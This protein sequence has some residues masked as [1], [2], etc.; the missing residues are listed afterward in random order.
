[1]SHT[2][3]FFWSDLFRYDIIIYIYLVVQF[4][5]RDSSQTSMAAENLLVNNCS[6]GQAIKAVCKC[7]PKLYVKPAF[8]WG[9]TK[10]CCKTGFWCQISF[11]TITF[12]L[13]SDWQDLGANSKHVA[14]FST[15]IHHRSHRCDWWR[16]TRGSPWAKRSFLDIWSCRRAEGRW[17]PATASLC[18][19]NLPGTGSWPL[20]GNLHTRIAS[21]SLCTGHG[22]HLE[23]H[24]PLVFHWYTYY[25]FTKRSELFCFSK[26]TY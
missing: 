22:Y 26:K 23:L 21:A 7:L 14:S 3:S 9:K 12:W 5:F 16:H 25:I 17:S 19:R 1:M 6:N 8:A 15:Y 4:W 18:Q 13:V 20:E 11:H 10:K 24:V 2:G